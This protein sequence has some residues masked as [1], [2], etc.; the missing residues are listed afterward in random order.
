MKWDLLAGHGVLHV[1]S[2]FPQVTMKPHVCASTDGQQGFMNVSDL[3]DNALRSCTSQSH[4]VAPSLSLIGNDLAI[5]DLV[6]G[7]MGA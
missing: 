2:F 4:H 1:T 6:L 3:E 5:G 7:S